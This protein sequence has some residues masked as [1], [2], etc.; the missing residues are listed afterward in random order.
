MSKLTRV[1]LAFA[2][3]LSTA[4]VAVA[5]AGQVA[6][7]ASPPPPACRYDDVLTEHIDTGDWSI[8]LL[9]PIYMLPKHYVPPNLASVAEANIEG[10]GKIRRIVLD[11]LA[12]MAADARQAGSPLRVTSAYRSWSK[13]RSLYQQEVTRFGLKY[14]RKSVARP[15]HSEHQLGTTIDFGSAGSSKN[16]WQYSDWSKTAAGAWIKQNGWK[17]GF[18]LSYPNGKKSITCYHYEPWHYRYV[19]REMAA[20]V[21]GTGLTLREYLWREY[22]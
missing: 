10:S 7:A 15:G 1:A 6:L 11:D 19:G 21:H 16:A 9:D 13:Q 3:A 12:E 5:G 22:H 8:S 2:F 20:D 18:L 4:A 14:A 17:Y